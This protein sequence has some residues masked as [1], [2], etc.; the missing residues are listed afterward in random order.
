MTILQ[1]IDPMILAMVLFFSFGFAL[2]AMVVSGNGNRKLKK[3][4]KTLKTKLW[5]LRRMK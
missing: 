1:Y 3:E 4:N 2:G 5:L